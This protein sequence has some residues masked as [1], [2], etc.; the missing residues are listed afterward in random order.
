M[1]AHATPPPAPTAAPPARASAALQECKY[2]RADAD[3]F[4]QLRAALGPGYVVLGERSLRALRLLMAVRAELA[5]GVRISQIG[6]HGT[7]LLRVYGNKGAV[8]CTL[9]L[10]VFG[11]RVAHWRLAKWHRR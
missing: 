2:R 1:A 5:A 10:G 3:W 4:A 9:G 8:G 7:G 11:A 6:A